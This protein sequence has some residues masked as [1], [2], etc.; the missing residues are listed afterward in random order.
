MQRWAAAVACSG[1]VPKIHQQGDERAF[2]FEF[3]NHPWA[4]IHATHQA[5][6]R[7]LVAFSRVCG[8]VNSKKGTT[9]RPCKGRPI[10]QAKKS[11]PNGLKVIRL[12]TQGLPPPV[13]R[14][15]PGVQDRRRFDPKPL[16]VTVK[17]AVAYKRKYQEQLRQQ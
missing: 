6:F 9:Q 15:W 7:D 1:A 12:M 4:T 8:S 3:H 17:G 5:W 16:I 13:M 2:D 14:K 11:E 10:R